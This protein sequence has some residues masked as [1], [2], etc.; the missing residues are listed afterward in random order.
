[1]FYTHKFKP[2]Q[3]ILWLLLS[4][5]T[6]ILKNL[7]GK[8]ME[9]IPWVVSF[10]LSEFL[11]P[12]LQFHSFCIV[13]FYDET[14]FLFVSR[15][16]HISWSMIR[17]VA[18]RS[19]FELLGHL[20]VAPWWSFCLFPW[21]MW[22]FSWVSKYHVILHCIWTL[23]ILLWNYGSCLNPIKMLIC[24]FDQANA[25]LVSSCELL[26]IISGL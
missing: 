13:C 25:W 23:L 7:R 21:E 3:T 9:S 11:F 26:S 18:L 8:T 1:M 12:K 24:L 4:T 19:Q 20:R 5:I 10:W 2:H 6:H 16:A 15:F 14:T 17:I 22:R